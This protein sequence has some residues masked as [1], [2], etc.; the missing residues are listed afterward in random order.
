MNIVADE[1]V[2]DYVQGEIPSIKDLTAPWG[3]KPYKASLADLEANGYLPPEYLDSPLSP[4][5]TA[6]TPA[7][8]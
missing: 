8:A 3:P 7:K 5:E 2:F 4:L 6:V 1:A